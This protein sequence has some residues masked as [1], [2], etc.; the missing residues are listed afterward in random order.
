[1]DLRILRESTSEQASQLGV[2]LLLVI[3]LMIVI[4]FAFTVCYSCMPSVVQQNGMVMKI[5]GIYSKTLKPFNDQSKNLS[6]RTVI[7][8]GGD[9]EKTAREFSLDC[10]QASPFKE[11]FANANG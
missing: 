9:L 3:G 8:V 6:G 2:V 5:N 4:L 11:S 10:E 1:M 7:G